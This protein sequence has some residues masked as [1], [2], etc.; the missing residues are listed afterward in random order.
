MPPSSN[1]RVPWSKAVC[2]VMAASDE[3]ALLGLLLQLFRLVKR[4]QR[5]DDRLE[6]AIHD[7]V[8]LVQRQPDP[9][10]RH[11]V[12]REVVGANLFAAISR[13]DH[14]APLRTQSG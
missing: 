12:L 1:S 3:S 7:E 6:L 9:V 2:A 10:I 4:G 13:P 8:K 5:V 11:A 14:A